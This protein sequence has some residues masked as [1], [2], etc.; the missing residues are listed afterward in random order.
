MFDSS[1]VKGAILGIEHPML[2]IILVG[3][4]IKL[5][6]MTLAF[7]FDTNY[8]AIVTKNIQ[9]GQ[10]LYGLDGYYYTPVWGYV[11]GFVSMFDSFF[12]DIGEL[13]IRLMDML[14]YEDGNFMDFSANVT[15]IGF[16]MSYKLVLFLFDLALAY[17]LYWL[18]GDVTKDERKAR[19]AFLLAFLCPTIFTAYAV[20]GMPDIISATMLMLAV[21][22][23]RRGHPMSAG[24][25]FAVA[26]LNKFFP[27]FVFFPI[28]G[29]AFS[30]ANDRR[31]GL[32]DVTKAAAGAL[33]MVIV[34]MLPHMSDGNILSAFSFITDR[35]TVSS[36][37][38]VFGYAKSYT[39][40]LVALIALAVSFVLGLRLAK[41]RSGDPIDRFMWYSLV[42]LTV[43]FVYP[44]NP[45]YLAS[46][47]PFL[48]Y[49]IIVMPKGLLRS[50]GLLSIGGTMQ[51]ASA[52]ATL[53]LPLAVFTDLIP[54][55]AVM[56][57][58]EMLYGN[59]PMTYM[60][61]FAIV[62]NLIQ[63]IG[64]LSI[65]YYVYRHRSFITDRCPVLADRGVDR[66]HDSP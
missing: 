45:Q 46:L 14:G 43:M 6:M 3:T 60:E 25:F 35:A 33:L 54:I 29:Y 48:I 31:E 21:V 16:M 30:M 36:D 28:V 11:L 9:M 47:F 8:W 27:A 61:M 34:I 2:A 63:Y 18:I 41:N 52:L 39:A 5:A 24:A 58:T 38:G 20:L 59:L 56:T 37:S 53:L 44:P 10:G 40:I 42:S 51:S 4:V 17:M 13:G 19:I 15:S 62:G 57:A 26:V 7:T 55:D 23:M 49:C 64:L 50:W 32:I 65:L 66:G 22:M 12:L 1:R